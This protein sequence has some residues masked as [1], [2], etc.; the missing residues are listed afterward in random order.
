M[1]NPD[2]HVGIFG[3]GLSGKT[4]LAK[5]LARDYWRCHGVKSLA[6][7]LNGEAWGPQ[8]WTTSDMPRFWR[9]FWHERSC[10]VFVDESA[11]TIDRDKS[12]R[13]VF[14]RSR[15]CGH[16]VHVTGHGAESLL[17]VMRKQLHTLFLFRQDRD[18][19]EYWA[20]LF[21]DDRIMEACELGQYEFLWCRLWFAPVRRRLNL[22]R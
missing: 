1:A 16:K 15:H 8:T 17:P 22:S 9:M 6:L 2:L 7:E 11:E 13:S 4:T 20:K 21:C 18:S 5:F 10:A 14:T 12:L 19:A 3:P